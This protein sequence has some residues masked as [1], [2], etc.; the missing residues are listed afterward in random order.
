MRKYR[1]ML[2]RAKA[3]RLHVSK[4]S[5]Y[6]H[7]EWAKYQVNKYGTRMVVANKAKG[8]HTK[9]QWKERISGALYNIKKGRVA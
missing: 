2:L 8:T 3:N 9:K 7:S 1:R 6:V 4:P 5:K